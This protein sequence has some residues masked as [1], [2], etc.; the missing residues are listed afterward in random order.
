MGDK[1]KQTSFIQADLREEGEKKTSGECEKRFGKSLLDC[2]S[3]PPKPQIRGR[4]GKPRTA[5]REGSQKL[6]WRTGKFELQV[7]RLL[8]HSIHAAHEGMAP[9]PQRSSTVS[10]P[11]RPRHRHA[12]AGCI[13]PRSRLWRSQESRAGFTARA[14][15]LRRLFSAAARCRLARGGRKES[16]LNLLEGI[17]G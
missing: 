5:D 15:R 14:E 17:Q 3:R 8:A 13:P 16:A 4:A 7:P 6:H 11:P 2:C 10:R 9:A 1:N 12:R